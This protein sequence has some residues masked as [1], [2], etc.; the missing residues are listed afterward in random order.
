LLVLGS[1][2]RPTGIGRAAFC[3]CQAWRCFGRRLCIKASM[4]IVRAFFFTQQFTLW[5]TLLLKRYSLW[6]SSLSR[7]FS[8]YLLCPF[9]TVSTGYSL[10]LLL[11]FQLSLIEAKIKPVLPRGNPPASHRDSRDSA[12]NVPSLPTTSTTCLTVSVV[13]YH[14]DKTPLRGILLAVDLPAG[15]PRC[16]EG[17]STLA[18]S[19][20]QLSN[21]IKFEEFIFKVHSATRRVEKIGR[22]VCR[23]LHARGWRACRA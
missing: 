1:R 22:G 21:A 17:S 9:L 3:I 12:S 7:Y 13:W 11:R 19:R 18:A 16:A 5:F 23:E 20:L 6:H 2:R 10:V 14:C 15:S 8:K 4:Y